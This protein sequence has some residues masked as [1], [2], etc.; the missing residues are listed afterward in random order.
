[1][2]PFFYPIFPAPFP[3]LVIAQSNRQEDHEDENENFP[4][5]SITPLENVLR[6][7]DEARSSPSTDHQDAFC[8]R[9]NVDGFQPDELNISIRYG[10]LI[11]RG[12]H[13]VRTS[14]P[15]RTTDS[16][17]HEHDDVEPDFVAKEF[18]RTFSLPTNVDIRKTHAQFYPRQ[19]LLVIEIPLQT[20]RHLRPIDIFLAIVVILS[21]NSMFRR[22]HEQS[23]QLDEILIDL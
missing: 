6:R 17:I 21:M 15:P 14:I 8:L 1:M 22:T 2:L 13:I 7:T 3:I 11:V 10:R 19:Q 9:L 5:P 16:L 12:R 18:K 4:P 20:R 23:R